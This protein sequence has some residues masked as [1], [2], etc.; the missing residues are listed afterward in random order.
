MDP[1]R[2]LVETEGFF[3]RAQARDL[4]YGDAT[5]TQLVRG[6]VWKRI[7]RGY[8]TFVDHWV[9]LSPESRHLARAH[10]VAHSLGH[11]VA[12]SGVSGLI[13]HGVATWGMPLGRVHVTRLDG[14]AGRSEGDVVH[15]EGF[16]LDSDVLEIEGHRVLSPQRCAIEAGSRATS[17]AALVSFDS[18]LHLR[19]CDHDELFRQFQLMS[20]WPFTRRLHIPV[21]MA[22]AAA[23]SVGESR[24]RWLFWATGLPAPIL[25]YDVR[26]AEGRLVGRCDWGWP[27]H[28]LLGE[29]DGKVKY[30][31]V[32]GPDQDP[33][34]VVFAE[35]RR[36][37][38]IR[39]VSGC[40]MVRLVWDDLDRPRVTRAR[41]EALLRRAG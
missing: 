37:D 19:M 8:Y 11:A 38:L 25:Q 13:E 9:G 35:K 40:A 14:A 23:E 2:Y 28:G 27:E 6:G 1:L 41:I 34:D 29:F 20:S 32:L 17:E 7:R 5:V 16:C 12:L 36:E 15:H 39:E 22:D 18:L 3:T 33:G 26:D 21:R 24:A 4:G 30:G 10:A 31:R